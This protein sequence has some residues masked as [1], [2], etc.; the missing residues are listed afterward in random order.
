MFCLRQVPGD[1]NCLFHSISLAF[2]HHLSGRHEPFQED[3]TRLRWYSDRL[4]EVRSC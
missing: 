4:R 3:S 1:G 2:L